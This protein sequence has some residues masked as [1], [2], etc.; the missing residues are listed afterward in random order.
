MHT[1]CFFFFYFL[2]FG[3]P[4]YQFCSLDATAEQHFTLQTPFELKWNSYRRGGEKNNYLDKNIAL[5][6]CSMHFGSV[7][8]CN[9]LMLTSDTLS[10]RPLE[11]EALS[12]WSWRLGQ[13]RNA[14]VWHR[15]FGSSWELA[16]ERQLAIKSD[17]AWKLRYCV[18]KLDVVTVVNM[19]KQF[20]RAISCTNYYEPSSVAASARALHMK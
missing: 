6:L 8:L 1:F 5:V 20:K 3:H 10:F 13:N 4:S 18:R 2:H 15:R 7:A 17:T 9:N 11:S 19:L 16:N 12:L 14:Q